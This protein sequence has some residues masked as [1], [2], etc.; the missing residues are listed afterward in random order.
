MRT[1]PPPPPHP[2][3]VP[4]SAI[5]AF[6][7][8]D[9]IDDLLRPWLPVAEERSLVVR[10]LLD[11][12]PAHHSGTN[13]VL[14]RLLGMVLERVGGPPAS[15]GSNDDAAAAIPLRLPPPFVDTRA[16]MRFPLTLP[17]RAVAQLAPRPS[18]HFAAMVDCL[19]DGPP[20]HALANAAMLHLIESIL[21][22][23]GDNMEE[24]P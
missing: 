12:G 6:V 23:L 17:T 13:Y 19:T 18:R 2:R 22:Q 5:T 8:R 16:E 20:Q 15:A 1:P 24:T 4:T 14:L 11:T 3:R 7:Q 21:T 10:C 9:A